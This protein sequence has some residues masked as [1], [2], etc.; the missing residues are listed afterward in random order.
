MMRVLL[1]MTARQVGGAEI[2]ARQLVA[3]LRDRCDFTVVISDHPA[4]RSLRDE[5]EG[6]ARVAP[7]PVDRLSTLP[8]VAV[9]VR[10]LAGGHD[11]VQLISNHPASRLGIMMGFVLS[12]TRAP[13]VVVEQR[14]TPMGDVDV[15]GALAPLL[16]G[17]FRR[18]RRRAARVIAV[19]E[20][21]RRTL[22][23]VYGLPA[24]A[25]EVVY[26]GVD[27]ARFARPPGRDLRIELNLHPKQPVVLTVARLLPNKGHR[28]LVEAAPEI[29]M[30][31]PDAHFIFAGDGAERVALEG[32][33]AA[34]DLTDRFSLVGFRDDVEDVLRAGDVFVL[35]SL[36]EGF[37]LSLV[38][39]LAAGLP[40]IATR[41][42]G[43]AEVIEHGIN[44]FLAPPG[45]APALAEGVI[46]ALT[47]DDAGRQRMSMAAR[48]TAERFS[49]ETMAERMFAIYE[50]ASYL[51]SAMHLGRLEDMR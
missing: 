16:P 28:Y 36:A 9:E 47:L 14:A 46:T 32:Q 44:G 48:A 17:L 21:N 1:V 35:P 39:A 30:R 50:D 41:V 29:L 3:A 10:R 13:L 19:S 33:V 43:A 12:G 6:I 26:N 38:E 4:M 23:D 20:E 5:L 8:Q 27:L 42:G 7:L 11:V 15:R 45:D 40:V 49:V 2:Y 25:V 34:L 24:S 18:S 31:F 51:R 22:E 37:A